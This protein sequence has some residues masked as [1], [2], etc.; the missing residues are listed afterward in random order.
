MSLPFGSWKMQALQVPGAPYFRDRFFGMLLKRFCLVLPSVPEPAL[1]I[2]DV[3]P[4]Q[5]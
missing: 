2:A 5:E 3:Q 1:P 4:F